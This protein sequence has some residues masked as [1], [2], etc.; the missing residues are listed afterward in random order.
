MTETAHVAQTCT[1]S[2]LEHLASLDHKLQLIRDRTRGVA[3][4]Y[5]T[6]FYLWGEGGTSK[7]FTVEE[8]LNRL[9]KQFKLSNSRM[10]GKGLFELLRDF[11]DVVHVLDDVETLFSDKNSFGVLRS[12]LWGQVGKNGQQERPVVWHIGGDRQE[13]CFTGG[14]ILI[15]NCPLDNVPQLRALR[16]RIACVRYQPTNAELAAL[17]RRIAQRGY[18]HGPHFLVPDDCLEVAEQ[19]IARSL[20]LER[21]VDLRLFVNACADRLQWEH[22][23]AETHW[24]DLL[25]SRLKERTVPRSESNPTRAEKTASELE[26]VRSIAHLPRL[27]RLAAWQKATGKS[28]ATLYRLLN[29]A[30]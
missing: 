14:I 16:T 5:A 21:N 8:T 9:V 17:M 11:P 18:R 27:A 23:A 25:E 7:S 22:G 4:G 3:E 2:D 1:N 15:A 20:R 26:V 13:F 10:T 12:A 19:I 30:K 28:Q 29:K 24:L 6:G